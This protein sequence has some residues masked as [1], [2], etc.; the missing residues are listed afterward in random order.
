M[1]QQ[2]KKNKI[3]IQKEIRTPYDALRFFSALTHGIGA[4]MF[5]VGV[6]VLIVI[7]AFMHSALLIIGYSVYGFSLIGLYT[8]STIYHCL[9]VQPSGRATL[10]KLDH[11]MIYMLIS[12]TY[13]PICL[14]TLNGPWGWSIFGVIWGLAII[15]SV[16]KLF[17]FSA[18][19]WISAAAYIGMGWMAIV[20]IVPLVQ[21]MPGTAM[22]L[23]GG[24]GFFYTVGGVFYALRWPLRERKYF[25]FHEVFH[26]FILLGSISHF[27]M[28]LFL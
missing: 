7:A 23:L 8:T 13:T 5:S 24:G 14:I 26:V 2:R 10:R 20:A 22:A 12:G 9:R 1:Y 19:R 21:S 27:A 6:A 3:R 17:W 4:W 16:I 28:M 25:G 11:I 15:G 18:P